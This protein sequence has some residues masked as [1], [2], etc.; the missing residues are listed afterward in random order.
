MTVDETTMPDM[1]MPH[2][3]EYREKGPTT[4]I[5]LMRHER[6]ISMIGGAALALAG[7]IKRGWLGLGMGLAGGGLMMRGATGNS[8]IMRLL[9]KNRAVVDPS[10]RVAVPHNQGMRVEDSIVIHRSA[11]ELYEF[12]RDFTHLAEFMPHVKSIEVYEGNRSKWVVEGPAGASVSWDAEIVNDIPNELI[13]WRTVSGSVVDHAGSVRFHPMADGNSTRVT[14]TFE[15]APTGGS[16]GAA[17]ARLFGKAPEQ[18]VSK[19]LQQLKDLMDGV[20]IRR[21]GTQSHEDIVELSSDESFPASDP[22]G[23]Y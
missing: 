13:A 11:H 16:V 8:M 1:S 5:N 6:L 4:K 3:M 17:V 9:G 14:V 23:Y 18:Q 22:P 19:A 10:A 12:W 7:M 20:A 15:Y 21:D 2:M